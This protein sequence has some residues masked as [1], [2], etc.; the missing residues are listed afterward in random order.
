MT[1][2]ER[3]LKTRLD[4]GLTQEELAKKAGYKSR[5]TIAKI[6]AGERDAPQ[7]M[8]VAL[9]KALGTTPSYLM[10]WDEIEET[11][12][13][14]DTITDPDNTSAQIKEQDAYIRKI[15]NE[16]HDMLLH[17]DSEI[18]LINQYR[19]LDD[20]GKE[21]INRVLAMEYNRCISQQQDKPS[22][23]RIMR[24][25]RNGAPPSVETITPEEADEIQ[26]RTLADPDM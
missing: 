4:K 22:N 10:G 2:G 5:S 26:N 18:E 15:I 19:I 16:S 11:L 17:D 12:D 6:E 13:F 3:I 20:Y 7:S 21:M 8:I 24:A 9:A 23:I 14:L 25:A 1:F